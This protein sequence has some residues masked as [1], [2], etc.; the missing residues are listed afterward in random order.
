MLLFLL[1]L[2]LVTMAFFLGVLVAHAISNIPISIL[3]R[4][5]QAGR[6]V[7]LGECRP[8]LPRTRSRGRR[9]PPPMRARRYSPSLV[10]AEGA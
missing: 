1:S 3:A 6:H 8:L 9:S 2:L 4:A 7:R 5:E 10:G